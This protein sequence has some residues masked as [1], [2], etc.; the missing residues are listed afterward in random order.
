MKRSEA[1]R[2][3]ARTGASQDEIAARAKVSRQ[4]VGYWLRDEKHPS[5]AKRKLIEKHFR[6]PIDAWDEPA[7]PTKMNGAAPPAAPFAGIDV[8]A[9]YD[10]LERAAFDLMAYVRTDPDA[11]PIER[12]KVM[13]SIAG[14]LHT[15]DTRQAGLE[16]RILHTP[17]WKRIERALIATLR[18]FPEALKAINAMLEQLNEE[19]SDHHEQ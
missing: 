11:T 8:D 12:A 18:G 6:V 1:A 2:L 7:K 9:S 17:R 16:K 13:R 14:T 15:L 3:L 4:A 19:G 10:E 5:K